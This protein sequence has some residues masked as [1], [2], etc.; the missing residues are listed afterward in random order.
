MMNNLHTVVNQVVVGECYVQT[1][2]SQGRS[3]I[4]GLVNG[5]CQEQKVEEQ[6]AGAFV[7]VHYN[8]GSHSF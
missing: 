3:A 5:G 7:T 6:C 4:A 1:G 8:A 2:L